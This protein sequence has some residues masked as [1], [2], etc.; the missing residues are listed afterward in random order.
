[1]ILSIIIN[2]VKLKNMYVSAKYMVLTFVNQILK[3]IHVLAEIIGEL[4][5][6]KIILVIVKRLKDIHVSVHMINRN[7]RPVTKKLK[8]LYL[9]VI[10]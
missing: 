2:I 7:V 8:I 9:M 6:G 3:N 4:K 10:Y 5:L 1:M